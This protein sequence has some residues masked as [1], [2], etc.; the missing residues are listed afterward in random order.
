MT[1]TRKPPL[2]TCVACRANAH[3]RELVRVVRNKDGDVF[4]DAT[5]R[6]NG[7]GAY[8]CAK[9]ECFEEAARGRLGTALR[10]SLREE[11]VDRLRLE[12]EEAAAA[13]GASTEGR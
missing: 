6:A 2:R 4:V 11:D 8:V 5:G 13:R 1:S 10:T 12:F 7:R 3:K 9:R